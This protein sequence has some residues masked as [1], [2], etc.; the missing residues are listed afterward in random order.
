MSFDIILLIDITVETS[1]FIFLTIK[2]EKIAVFFP[3][4]YSSI[5]LDDLG[6]LSID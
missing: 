5:A 2:L 6:L 3:A 1:G 4:P